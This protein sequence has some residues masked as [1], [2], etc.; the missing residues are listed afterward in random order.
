MNF[1]FPNN[2]FNIS[3]DNLKEESRMR[4]IS[5]EIQKISSCFHKINLVLD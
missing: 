1:G 5:C 3:H 2:Y 4:M